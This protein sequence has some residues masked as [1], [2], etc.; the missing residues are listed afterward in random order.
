MA[1]KHIEVFLVDGKPGGLTTAEIVNWTGH[2]LSAQRSDMS[3]LLARKEVQGTCVYFLLGEQDGEARAYI[4]ET[5]DFPTRLRH[6]HTNK[7]FWN[8]VVV[9]TSKDANLTKTHG[10]YLESQ[11]VKLARQAR[12]VALENGNE[13]GGSDLPESGK[14]DMAHF[15]EELK[16]ILPVL[17][18]DA[19][20]VPEVA[21]TADTHSDALRSAGADSPVFQ[22]VNKK[23]GY[24][25]KA[26]QVDGEFVLLQGS[27]IAPEVRTSASYKE[28]TARS[29]AL[30]AEQHARLVADGAVVV[31]GPVAC[32][33]RNIAFSSPSAAGAIVQG[34]SC[35]G[36]TS[37]LLED[38][39]SFGAWES[40]DVAADI[41]PETD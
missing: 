13:P 38:G 39:T 22:L 36:R 40:R 11:L 14:S 6:H 31:D 41:A 4:G 12:R 8:R 30:I 25:A 3:K 37:W 2:V 5:D 34:G 1:G 32:T 33:T 9:I 19:I 27:V 35:N 23:Q 7:E 16:I 28:G 20:R 21:V 15:I 10:R 26:R 18:V 29:Y 17:G 24:D